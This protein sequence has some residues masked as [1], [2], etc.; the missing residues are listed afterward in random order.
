[1]IVDRLV[2]RCGVRDTLRLGPRMA[3]NQASKIYHGEGREPRRTTE[4]GNK[5]LRAMCDRPPMRSVKIP[6]AP[7]PPWLS[8]FSVAKI[9][10]YQDRTPRP[11][12]QSASGA[13]PQ[14]CV[15]AIGC[16][17]GPV[18]QPR[19]ISDEPIDCWRSVDDSN[20]TLSKEPKLLLVSIA[21][22][23]GRRHES[24]F[25]AQPPHQPPR[26]IPCT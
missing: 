22:A 7:G 24:L 25:D 6:I 21:Q 11:H 1:M 20:W 5:A 23:N 17:P 9:L 15:K 12:Q 10:A 19:S 16:D 26:A 4:E 18:G 8:A 14:Q 2:G 3:C 13:P